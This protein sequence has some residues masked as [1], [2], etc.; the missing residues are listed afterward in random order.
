MPCTDAKYVCVSKC[1]NK[2]RPYKYKRCADKFS[3]RMKRAGWKLYSVESLYM[4]SN[5]Y[6]KN[7]ELLP[8]KDIR[9]VKHMLCPRRT[10]YLI[11]THILDGFLDCVTWGT[12]V[13]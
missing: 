13:T 3:K 10:A 11:D 4:A 8:F 5:L 7:G 9:I 12:S 2:I 6:L 1:G